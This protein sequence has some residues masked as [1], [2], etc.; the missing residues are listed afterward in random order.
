[1]VNVAAVMDDLATA[2]DTIPDLRVMAFPADNAQPPVALVGYPEAIT[3]DVTMGRGVDQL[4]FPVFVLVGRLTDR[5][6]RDRLGAY[7]D[8]SGAESVKQALKDG[9]YT[10]MSSVRVASAVVDV[11]ALAA[12]EYL[13]AVFTVNVY[14]A[15]G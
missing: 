7:L 4:D 5:T 9:T 11:V 8:G 3:Y 1:M 10:A 15:G 14:G 2:L 13:A 6:V 12:V